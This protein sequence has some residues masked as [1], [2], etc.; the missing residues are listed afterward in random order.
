VGHNVYFDLSFLKGEMSQFGIE[1][2]SPY[3][4][5]MGF[6]GFYGGK[7]RQKLGVSCADNKISLTNAHTALADTKATTEL[8]IAHILKAKQKGLH[9]F[10]DLKKTKKNYKFISSWND[11][12]FSYKHFSTDFLKGISYCR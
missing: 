9:T 5:T 12:L 1:L 4:C 6:P 7:S 3:M 11:G 8:L 10:M 2:K